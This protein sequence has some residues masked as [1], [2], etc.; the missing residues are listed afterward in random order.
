[1]AN[2]T[3]PQTFK[4]I[5]A[6]R[7]WLRKHHASDTEVWVLIAK[8]HV[9]EPKLSYGEVIDEALCWGWIDGLV[10]RWDE[11]YRAQ[12]LSPRKVRSVW[13]A[14]NIDKIARLEAEGRLQ[15]A[16]RKLVE[17]A[18]AKGTW[19]AGVR[20]KTLAESPELKRALGKNPKARAFY[21]ALTPGRRRHRGR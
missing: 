1:M 8:K 17:L 14:I 15:P 10:N 6:W 19:A 21:E 7:T 13:S 2:I 4:S 9:P 12:R 11:D 16:G 5:A 18:K 3:N 20:K